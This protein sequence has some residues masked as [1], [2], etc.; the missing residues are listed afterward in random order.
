MFYYI[1][2]TSSKIVLLW[3][4]S[5]YKKKEFNTF[6]EQDNKNETGTQMSISFFLTM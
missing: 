4:V 2:N 3:M 1:E 6:F 5:M